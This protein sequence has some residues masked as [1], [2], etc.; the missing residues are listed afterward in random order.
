MRNFILL[1]LLLVLTGCGQ[2][3]SAVEAEYEFLAPHVVVIKSATKNGAQS[4]AKENG[5]RKT[6][7]KGSWKPVICW[8]VQNVDSSHW[9]PS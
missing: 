9:Q 5:L 1:T 7:K 8:S 6:S 2:E 4:W 3:S